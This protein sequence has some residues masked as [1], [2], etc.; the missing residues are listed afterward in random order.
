MIVRQTTVPG[1]RRLREWLC[2]DCGVDTGE[3]HEYYMVADDLWAAAGDVPGM[4]CIGCL[5]TR[6]GRMLTRDDFTGAPVNADLWPQ[7]SRLRARLTCAMA[8]CHTAFTQL[9]L[10]GER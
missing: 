3:V 7:S 6:L 5:E 4:L 10:W 2:V 9:A 8:T 1:N